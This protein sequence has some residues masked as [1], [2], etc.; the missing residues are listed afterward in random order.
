MKVERAEG[1][2]SGSFVAGA[3][4]LA[5]S[6]ELRVFL[7]FSWKEKEKKKKKSA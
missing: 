6:D 5:F 1:V 7:S 4:G 3:G 2:P